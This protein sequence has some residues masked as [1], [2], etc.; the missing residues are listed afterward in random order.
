VP[1]HDEMIKIIPVIDIKDGV[2]VAA[3]K[4]ERDKY[5]PLDSVICGSCDP[6]K[7]A[8]AYKSLGFSM[9]YA[10]DLDGILYSR[11]N[12][13]LLEKINEIIPVIADTGVKCKEDALLMKNSGCIGIVIGTETLHSIDSLCE[14]PEQDKKNNFNFNFTLSLDIKNGRL[15]NT[16]NPDLNEFI[17]KIA[18]AG[19]ENRIDKIIILGLSQVGTLEGPNIELCSTVMKKLGNAKINKKIIYGGG[20]RNISDIKRLEDAGIY[21]VLLG[22]ALHFGKIKISECKGAGIEV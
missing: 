1:N 14:I 19:I 16:L 20:V 13:G 5:K 10:A 9:V 3:K 17:E 12:V 8:G 6:L 18:E 4:G 21:A 22:T 2:A 15:L 7:V 11:P